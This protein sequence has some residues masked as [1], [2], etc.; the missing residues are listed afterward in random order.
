MRLLLA[1]LVCGVTPAWA[2]AQTAVRLPANDTIVA[3][4]WAGAAHRIHDQRSWHGNLLVGLSSG[5]YW[6]DHVKTEFEASWNSLRKHQVYENI[7]R[8]GGYTYALSEYRASDVRAGVTQLYQF[9]RN[10]WVHPYV[11]V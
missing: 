3:I 8:Q 5:H 4:G 10:Q 6:T 7:E 2:A 1:M 9:G 11:G